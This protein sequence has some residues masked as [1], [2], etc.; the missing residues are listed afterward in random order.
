IDSHMADC[1]EIA[2]MFSL[3]LLRSKFKL[4]I[5]T[6]RMI[7]NYQSNPLIIIFGATGCGKTRLSLE[8]AKH[9]PVE[10][11]SADS[12]QI[13]KALDIATNKASQ[14]ERN[15]VSHHLIDIIEPFESFNVRNYQI[16][17]LKYRRYYC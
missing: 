15:S 4:F 13:Y 12:M 17:A 11:I 1:F 10:I 8:L 5:S 2:A 16:L 7:N 3:K 14:Q 9:F 6:S